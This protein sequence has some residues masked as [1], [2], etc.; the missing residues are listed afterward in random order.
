M[1]YDAKTGRS[2]PTNHQAPLKSRLIALS[3]KMVKDPSNSNVEV[4]NG[5]SATTSWSLIDRVKRG[6]AER[7]RRLC[8]LYRPL[9][10]ARC[11]SR[12]LSDTESEDIEQEVFMTVVR[13]IVGFEK[14]PGPS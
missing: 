3:E 8:Y 12:G 7:W 1:C 4:Q 5:V 13:K 14:R 9:V 6:E 10:R 2:V 11:R